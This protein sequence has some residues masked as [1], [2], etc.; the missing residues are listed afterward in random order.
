M[1]KPPEVGYSDEA[2]DARVGILQGA[3]QTLG[4]STVKK[5]YDQSFKAGEIIEDVPEDYFAGTLILLQEGGDYQT[6]VGVGEAWL[7]QHPRHKS[8]KDVALST[9]LAHCDIAR[10]ILETRGS[11]EKAL[12]ALESA[13]RL[14]DI[15]KT[16]TH[17]LVAQVDE[18]AGDLLSQLTLDLLSSS[19]SATFERGF[20]YLPSALEAVQ[21]RTGAGEE[22][23]RHRH[24][25]TRTQYVQ[26]LGELLTAEQQIKL[27]EQVGELFASTPA[28]LYTMA[29]AYIAAGAYAAKP[30]LLRK[31]TE[32]LG[33]AEAAGR[34]E[35]NYNATEE[36]TEATQAMARSRRLVD[37]GHR[38]AVASCVAWL[39]L[40]DSAAA[41]DA[42]GLT[43]GRI[44]CD[45]Q[46]MHFIR[47]NSPEVD[48]LL[49]GVCALTQRWVADVAMKSFHT[50]GDVFNSGNFTLDNWF[51]NAYVVKELEESSSR[52]SLVGLL[53]A[54]L[55]ALAGLFVF[56]DKKGQ[57]NAK[58]SSSTDGENSGAS[59]GGDAV[60]IRT[61]QEPPV[62]ALAAAARVH[63]SNNNSGPE[64]NQTTSS[65]NSSRATPSSAAQTS[66]PES[67]AAV[68]NPPRRSNPT[69]KPEVTK[70]PLARREVASSQPEPTLE[71][72]LAAFEDESDA[73]KAENSTTWQPGASSQG[74]GKVSAPG[75]DFDD[76][77]FLE[78]PIS[79]GSIKPLHGEDDFMRK[80]YY[81]PRSIRWG[82]VATAAAVL[83]GA[84][85][86][87]T[88]Y[89][90]NSMAASSTSTRRVL[91]PTSVATSTTVIKGGNTTPSSSSSASSTVVHNLSHSEAVSLIKQWQKIKAS[92]LG[93]DHSLEKLSSVLSG[94]LF[95]QWYNRAAALKVKGWYY[96]H[97]LHSSKVEKVVPGPLPGTATITVL[98]NE[99]VTV[100]KGDADRDEIGQTF[101]S[102]YKVVYQAVKGEKGGW[103]LISAIV[104]QAAE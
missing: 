73:S 31:A 19:D 46:V 44:K 29:I 96:A 82:R 79:L 98:F 42:L 104:Q 99:G 91:T 65:P 86:F 57:D 37:E 89:A 83:G 70:L 52:K 16:G 77:F 67:S 22:A 94:D 81:E 93:K 38:R 87:I 85:F 4:D 97:T 15:Y 68:V 40:G 88:R 25:L 75:V 27:Y 21:S 10:R 62:S 63:L 5:E 95:D 56:N 80:A 18:A 12:S 90:L 26:N 43:D 47:A 100:H 55:R 41:G 64:G 71:S 32:V 72:A 2:L 1:N 48:S 92:A 39:L 36:S 7:A 35:E 8:I 50:E 30:A 24:Q 61:M 69:S 78:Q 3:L 20:E 23:A 76:S 51:E 28:E 45:R 58:A 66:G 59:S 74:Q 101:V 102:E 103:V 6:V 13:K 54:P 17:E 49:P 53:T 9:A 33:A 34:A 60:R 11:V 14:L 84:G